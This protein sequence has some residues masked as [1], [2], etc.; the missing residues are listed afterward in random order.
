MTSAL[1]KNTVQFWYLLCPGE[2]GEGFLQKVA[3]NRALKAE[4]IRQGMWG[5]WS[6]TEATACTKALK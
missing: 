5:K 1:K 3:V 4:V 2:F 6:Q